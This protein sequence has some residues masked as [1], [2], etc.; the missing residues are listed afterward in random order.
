MI[1]EVLRAD[2]SRVSQKR[3]VASF[4]GATARPNFFLVVLLRFCQHTKGPLHLI[5]KFIYYYLRMLLCFDTPANT[6]IGPGLLILHHGN[7]VVN[8]NAA[9][10]CN[11]TIGNGVTI[12]HNFFGR[13]LGV[14]TL[15]DNV[16]IGTGAKIIGPIRIG[17]NVIIGANAVVVKDVPDNAVVAGNPARILRTNT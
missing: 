5:I 14:P 3:T 11:C 2:F 6:K 12:G 13:H 1:F 17:N 8:S 10:G 15:G 9:I 4:I 16:F 7:I